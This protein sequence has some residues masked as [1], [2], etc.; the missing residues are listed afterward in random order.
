MTGKY[1]DILALMPELLSPI[2]VDD[3]GIETGVQSFIMDAEI[4]AIDP[5]TKALLTFQ[6]LTNRARKDVNIHEVKVKVGVYA[7]D[8]MYLNGRVSLECTQQAGLPLSWTLCI[9]PADPHQQDLPG[10]T[11][12]AQDA[13]PTA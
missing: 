8:L 3:D 4:V 10:T 11:Q 13:L 6:T 7:F 9:D 1:P 2:V 5:V 12:S